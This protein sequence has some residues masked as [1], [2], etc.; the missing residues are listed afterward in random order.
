ML[1]SQLPALCEYVCIYKE[2]NSANSACFQIE[3][4]SAPLRGQLLPVCAAVQEDSAGC[5][6]RRRFVE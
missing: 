4:G 2:T 1:L 5:S 6:S 3:E